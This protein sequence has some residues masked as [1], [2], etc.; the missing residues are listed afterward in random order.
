M[1]RVITY[2][3]IGTIALNGI[4]MVKPSYA[5]ESNIDTNLK[6][7]EGISND[8]SI[9]STEVTASTIEQLKNH[10]DTQNEDLVIK[11]DKDFPNDLSEPIIINKAND[12]NL[13][14]DGSNLSLTP[15]TGYTKNLLSINKN[16]GGSIVI[17]NLNL[18]GKNVINE[19][20][21]NIKSAKGNLVLENIELI[22]SIGG[23]IYLASDNENVE[24]NNLKIANNKANNSGAAVTIKDGSSFNIEIN[25]S[26]IENNTGYGGGYEC[27]AIS[28]KNYY[29]KIV[30]NNT[31]LKSNVNRCVNTGVI[32]GGGGAMSFHYLR[33]HIEINESYFY[34][35]KTNGQDGDVKSTY[36]GGAIY[37]FDG[38]D[39]ASISIDKTTFDSNLA[40]DDGGAMMIQGTGNPGLTTNITNC[41]FYNNRAY[42]LTG[43]S[44]SGGAIQYFKNGGSSKV[45]NT[46]TGS[47]FVKNISGCEDTKVNQTG[48]SVGLSGAG[49]LATASVTRNNT[50]FIGNEVYGSDGQINKASNYKDI[51]NNSTVQLDSNL[52]NADKGE[53]PQYTLEDV[54][55]VNNAML[56][57]NNSTIKAGTDTNST[58]VPTIPIKPEGLAD[59]T[60]KVQ[61]SA[62]DQR[63]FERYKDIGAVEIS[64]IKY[65]ANGGTFELEDSNPFT[66]DKY[67]E[68]I[69]SNSYFDIGYIKSPDVLKSTIKSKE[70]L[71]A[72]IND[73]RIFVGWSRDKDAT[74]PDSVLEVGNQIH[75]LADNTTLYAV[76]K[77]GKVT[78]KYET[79]G[80]SE[81]P[82]EMLDIGS[83]ANKPTDPT[84]S[85]HKFSGW[86][87]DEELTKQFEF[88]SEIL[89]DT[90]LYAKWTKTGGGGGTVDPPR[91]SKVVILASGE[92]Y[93]DVLTATVLAN[94]KNC[95]ILLTQKDRVTGET[96]NEIKR[97]DVDA[98][99]ISGGPASVSEKVVDQLSE[100]KVIR[101][102]GV[103]RYE[104][105]KEIG[106]VVRVISGNK[107]QAMLVDGTNFPDV[108]TISSLASEKRAPILLTEPECLNKTTETAFNDWGINDITIGGSYNSVSQAVENR[109]G[110]KS[111]VRYGGVDRYK[112]A[113]LIG[114]QV[115]KTSG[116]KTDMILVDGTDFPDG[117]TVNSLA[118][119]YGAPI[120]ITQP[121]I[122]NSIVVD[123]IENWSIKNVLIAGGIN[124][125]SQGIEDSLPS[126]GVVNKERVA[127]VDRY[128]TAIRISQRLSQI[129]KALG[130]K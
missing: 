4:H 31:I 93:T 48:G 35:N 43:G 124:S 49:L 106:D 6:N 81:V 61:L 10:L 117:I 36:D 29:G 14:I 123:R 68:G 98:V 116:N 111:V 67:Y 47:T 78:V 22:N 127:G 90:T 108:I 100:Y 72:T 54:L 42:G 30:I 60:S 46:L 70:E 52:L 62:N 59:N 94:E 64:W 95:P 41:T 51:S 16:N 110:D 40:Y 45:T 2:I 39:G 13:I 85:G 87:T 7:V 44:A 89:E 11:L 23:A 27:G 129:N 55:G 109:L 3:L 96:L 112:T 101:L 34:A 104:T 20:L 75:F 115:R 24:L 107:N 65:D 128:Q 63:T 26:I 57:N 79:N 103:D 1:K 105:A 58:V 84:K 69:G 91:D 25:K 15:D 9:R 80:G 50:L 88:G 113:E 17:K 73:G 125:V 114:E 130:F 77:I 74:E 122:L 56:T 92:K 120:M 126:L 119:R 66:G 82:D 97:L 8:K 28:S 21:I 37:I 18:D 32:G 102:S 76:W 33:G 86:F 53:N 118:G 71:K 121:T 83:K 99:I 38:R 12:F 19:R 5:L